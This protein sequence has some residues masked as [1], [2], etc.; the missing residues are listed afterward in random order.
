MRLPRETRACRQGRSQ[1]TRQRGIFRFDPGCVR[2]E[3]RDRFLGSTNDLLNAGQP[4]QLAL[5]DCAP[6]LRGNIRGCLPARRL[7]LCR[8][9]VAPA[10]E[11]SLFRHWLVL[12]WHPYLKRYF[13]TASAP[14]APLANPTVPVSPSRCRSQAWITRNSSV[15]NLSRSSSSLPASPRRCAGENDGRS[16]FTIGVTSLSVPKAV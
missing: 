10:R 2:H 14:T 5:D 3:A 4:E 16:P 11:P 8:A 9:R 12:R 13:P 1:T 6:V 7:G 15:L